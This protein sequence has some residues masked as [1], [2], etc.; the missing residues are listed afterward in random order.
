MSSYARWLLT[1]CSAALL[2]ACGAALAGGGLPGGANLTLALAAVAAAVVIWDHW[3][4]HGRRVRELRVRSGLCGAC[5]YDL[6]ASP[7]RCPECGT[8]AASGYSRPGRS[9][10]PVS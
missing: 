5:G 8:A 4:S 9:S 1:L 3:A 2:L 10:R 7:G 6:R